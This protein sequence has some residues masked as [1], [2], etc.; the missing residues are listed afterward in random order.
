MFLFNF[1]DMMY[2]AY[3]KLAELL[4]AQ[5]GIFKPGEY[6]PRACLESFQ[7]LL[8]V[9]RKALIYEIQK[10]F[11]PS[12]YQNHPHVLFALLPSI[13]HDA[14]L[15]RDSELLDED[16]LLIVGDVSYQANQ[17]TDS[18]TR[19]LTFIYEAA[20]WDHYRSRL[21][22]VDISKLF[23]QFKDEASATMQQL[24]M[25]DQ[26]PELWYVRSSCSYSDS[27]ENN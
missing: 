8:G 24:D 2:K 17:S 10:S 5:D 23:K 9:L 1:H 21:V 22:G 14:E 19:L 18:G 20:W 15:W 4:D 16:D 11:K 12:S 26:M 27:S 6:L 13:L 25:Q 3:K 7:L